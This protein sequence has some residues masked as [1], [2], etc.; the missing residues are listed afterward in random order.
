M[1][2]LRAHGC[3]SSSLYLLQTLPLCWSRV[4]VCSLRFEV[5][6]GGATI[7]KGGEF[8]ASSAASFR[9]VPTFRVMVPSGSSA[10]LTLNLTAPVGCV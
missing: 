2:S 5:Q 1:P 7:I 10:P 9:L 4:C 3:L 8:A 6:Y